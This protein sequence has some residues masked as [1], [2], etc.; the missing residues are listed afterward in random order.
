MTAEISYKLVQLLHP[1]NK[2]LRNQG[3]LCWCLVK[4]TLPKIGYSK[5]EPVAIFDSDDEAYNF[6]GFVFSNKIKL[7]QIDGMVE[8]GFKKDYGNGS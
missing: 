2:E 7:I 4:V 1:F 8:A 6:Q 5:E 3:A